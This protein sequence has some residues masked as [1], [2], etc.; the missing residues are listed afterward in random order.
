[1][2]TR[3]IDIDFDVHKLIEQQRRSFEESPND[4][5]RRLLGVGPVRIVEGEIDRKKQGLNARG[6]FLPAGMKLRKTLKGKTHYAEIVDEGIKYGSKSFASPSAAAC[7]AAVNTVNGW[8]F[9][10]YERAPG[11]WVRLTNLKK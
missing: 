7:E 4:V 3:Q 2:K 6:V 9:W 10:H 5:L 8:K 11:D 1:M